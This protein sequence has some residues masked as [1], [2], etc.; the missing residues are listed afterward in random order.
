M[1]LDGEIDRIYGVPLDEFVRARDEL[2][3]RLRGEGDREA[4]QAVKALRKPT[5]GAWA[6]NQAVRRRRR[7]TETLL[8]A[9]GRLRAAHEALLEGGDPAALREAMQEERIMASTLA[10][11]AEAIDLTMSEYAEVRS[12]SS[13]YAIKPHHPFP[14]GGEPEGTTDRYWLVVSGTAEEERERRQG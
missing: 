13:R 6:L 10:D 3:K 9:G 4:A 1:E 2:A 7:E 5:A 14:Q 12:G 8:A 11:C